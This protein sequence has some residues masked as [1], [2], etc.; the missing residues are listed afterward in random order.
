MPTLRH[1]LSFVVILTSLALGA[2]TAIQASAA[3]GIVYNALY[4]CGPNRNKFKVVDC[5]GATCN[6]FYVNAA[7]QG[8]GYKTQVARSILEHVADYGCFVKGQGTPGKPAA[9]NVAKGAAA[10]AKPGAV[11]QAG[12]VAVAPV[13]KAPPANGSVV[14]GQYEC[15][16]YSG[17]H[18]Y[19]A[20]SENFVIVGAAAYTDAAGTPGTFTLA[21][22]ILTFQGGALSGHRAQ[23][24]PGVPGS[25]NP[26]HI[27]LLM[28]DGNPG[29][30]CDGKG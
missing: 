24:T 20:M 13:V 12:P 10:T 30:T 15:H 14:P 22:N 5:S 6:V 29:D 7:M 8:G 26:P 2:L 27:A 19:S 25:N 17:G 23:Y 4:D 11:L 16:S 3:S 1:R 28:T 9:G 21:G 18:L